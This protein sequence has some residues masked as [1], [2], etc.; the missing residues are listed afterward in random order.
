M[1]NISKIAALAVVA[2]LAFTG[3][4]KKN[5]EEASGSA[6]DSGGSG[7]KV[8][9]AYDGS[10]RGD[11]SFNDAAYA[12]LEKAIAD[13][14]ISCQEATPSGDDSDTSRT[15]RLRTL[16]EQ[17]LNPVIGIGYAYSNAAAAV[18]PDYPET[19]FAV[20]DG[21][22][23]FVVKKPADNLVDLTFTEEQGSY[24]VGVAAALTTESKQIGF[25]GG[26]NGPLISK[27]EAGFE[28]GIK[29]IDP[30]IKVDVKFLT[31][32]PNDINTAFFNPSGATQ[33]AN[34]MLDKGDDV[35]FQVAGS[36]GTG[37]IEAVTAAGDGKWVIGVDSD[38]YL[39]ASADQKPHMLTSMLKRVDT[40]VYDYIKAF[41]DGKAPSGNQTFDLAHDGVGYS[42]SGGFVKDIQD[43]I[44]AAAADIKSGK[45]VVPTEPAK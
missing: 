42:T 19:D 23:Q 34:G 2:S 8:G 11:K 1:R 3:C 22:S 41:D 5:N 31:T 38:Q 37:V 30:S 40:A 26:N 35:I 29:S 12:G 32:D 43:Q 18:A 27:F 4:G 10:G 6:C 33:A 14:D 17:G 25:V 44:D 21:F 36:S 39:T 24:L 13:L 45:V 20:I 7:P 28:A 16:A 9:V 15:E